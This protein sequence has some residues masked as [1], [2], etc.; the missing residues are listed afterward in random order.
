MWEK[1]RAER[2]Q[3][4]GTWLIIFMDAW[5]YPSWLILPC[6]VRKDTH[7][8]DAHESLQTL[9][10]FWIIWF[11]R[12]ENI[13]LCC[14]LSVIR[15]YL[16]NISYRGFSV[17]TTIS[18]I[19]FERFHRSNVG[20]SEMVPSTMTMA[21]LTR[22]RWLV[23]LRMLLILDSDKK[24]P[25][26]FHFNTCKEFYHTCKEFYHIQRTCMYFPSNLFWFVF[27]KSSKFEILYN[28]FFV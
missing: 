15:S 24:H 20:F 4:P 12:F 22:M 25:L 11:R 21:V 7:Y 5:C 16:V 26:P 3:V 2:A 8:F 18:G 1:A 23:Y 9:S 6:H 27:T 28:F 13:L 19:W 17:I 14:P 10:T